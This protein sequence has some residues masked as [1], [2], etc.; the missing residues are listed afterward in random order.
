ML[1]GGLRELLQPRELAVGLAADGLR[2]G[3]RLEL[4][5][6]LRDLRLGRVAL[7]ELVL[8]RLELLAQ[9]V[10][11][12]RLVELGLDLRLDPRADRGDLELAGEDLREPPQP[13]PDVALLEQRLLLLGADPQR[14]RDHVRERGGVGE[15]GDGELQ[16]LRQV[17]DVLDDPAEGLLHVAHQRGQLRPLG[18]LVRGGLDRGD[19]VGLLGRRT[20]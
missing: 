3:D 11:A 1:R 13:A 2:Q 6:Q 4:L 19:E 17:G 15:V 10:L 9:D 8:D 14:A 18:E 16:L 7:A 20:P 5:A 12:L